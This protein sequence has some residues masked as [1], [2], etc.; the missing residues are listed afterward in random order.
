MYVYAN[1]NP[2]GLDTGDCVIRA[3]SILLNQSWDKI[4]TDLCLT[5]YS[6]GM[7]P[8]T[9]AV[10]QQFLK[11]YGY[12]MQLLPSNC[13]NCITVKEFSELYPK[14]RYFLATGDHVV[15]LIDGTFYDIFDSSNDTVVYYYSKKGESTA[16]LWRI[17]HN[18]TSPM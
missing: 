5:G 14:G 16:H 6:M 4:Y 3:L 7:M 11:Q 10:H 12:K 13:P 18:Y 9:N 1:P 2:L 8:S 17:I 15:A